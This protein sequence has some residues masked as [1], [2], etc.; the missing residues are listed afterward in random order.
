MVEAAVSEGCGPE[1]PSP[2]PMR[3]VAGRS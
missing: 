1:L 3:A 2:P